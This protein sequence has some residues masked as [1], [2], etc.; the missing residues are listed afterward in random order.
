MAVL[1]NR[2]IHKLALNEIFEY[3]ER[4]REREKARWTARPCV[5]W[6]PDNDTITAGVR[7]C[8]QMTLHI[9]KQALVTGFW[10]TR[11][12]FQGAPSTCM[13][14]N[15]CNFVHAELFVVVCQ[16]LSVKGRSGFWER[17]WRRERESGACVTSGVILWKCFQ[18]LRCILITAWRVDL[19]RSCTTV[20]SR[21]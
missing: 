2:I 14:G 9:C 1:H 6:R 21:P 5:T 10:E 18:L 11:L 15:W 19:C 16:S 4:E 13:P 3:R 20:R 8:T 17:D 7:S 12:H